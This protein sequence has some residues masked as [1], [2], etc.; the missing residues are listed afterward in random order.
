MLYFIAIPK[1]VVV[2]KYVGIDDPHVFTNA[3]YFLFCYTTRI[4]RDQRSPCIYQCILLFILSQ[5]E[6]VGI[7]DPHVFINAFYFLFCYA[8]SPWGLS[9][10]TCLSIF[11]ILYAVELAILYFVAMRVRGDRRSPRI[12]QCMLYF[13]L[14]YYAYGD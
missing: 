4:R 5:H 9:L 7:V 1:F 14:L 3:F 12:Y 6:C 2:H 10:P 8:T 13:I 11:F